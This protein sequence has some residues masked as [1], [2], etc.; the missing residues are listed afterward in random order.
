MATA[1]FVRQSKATNARPPSKPPGI[2]RNAFNRFAT[3]L[4]VTLTRPP[5]PG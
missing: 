4:I 5:V 2:F 3:S 1:K